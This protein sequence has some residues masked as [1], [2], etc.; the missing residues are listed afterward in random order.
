MSLHLKKTIG[1]IIN[2]TISYNDIEN[3]DENSEALLYQ[4]RQKLK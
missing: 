3:C 2:N 4:L 1:G